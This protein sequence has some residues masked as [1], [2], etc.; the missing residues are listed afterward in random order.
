MI[1]ETVE[2]FIARTK[3]IFERIG[4]IF[5]DLTRC[6]MYLFGNVNINN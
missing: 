5:L 1:L 2:A 6:I 4:S 3:V